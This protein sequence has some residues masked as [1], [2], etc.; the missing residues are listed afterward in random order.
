[1]A[2]L[3]S[4][5][6]YCIASAENA[7]RSAMPDPNPPSRRASVS[8]S[9]HRGGA[10]S[11]TTTRR[12]PLAERAEDVWRVVQD[13]GGRELEDGQPLALQRV[14]APRVTLTVPIRR[15]S[16]TTRDLDD[17]AVLVV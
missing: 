2:A 10:V 5:G 12:Q 14:A 16:E 3:N 1:M 4:C 9:Q 15:V 7:A 8:R 17:D 6:A 13:V 11:V